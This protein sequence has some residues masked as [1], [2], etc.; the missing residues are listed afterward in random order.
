MSVRPTAP[1]PMVAPS[2]RPSA[3]Y[4][5][6]SGR[7]RLPARGRVPPVG[8]R[9]GRSRAGASRAIA[10]FDHDDG[11]VGECQRRPDILLDQQDR[12]TLGADLGPGG[13]DEV[14]HG[15]GEAGRGLVQHQDGGLDQKRPGDGQHLPLAAR[16]PA[17]RQPMA[18]GEVGKEREDRSPAASPRR[19]PSRAPA[20][21]RF[22]WMVSLVKTLSVC[23][24]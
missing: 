15:G 20:S 9:P 19:R 17:R 2:T 7:P 3:R 18:L 5:S 1:S 13:E 8:S 11:P 21:S 24:T 4:C 23:G 6:I 22:S 16:E 14:D 12:R 10:A